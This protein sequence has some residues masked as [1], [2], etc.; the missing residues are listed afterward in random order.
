MKNNF[1]SNMWILDIGAGCHYYRSLEGLTEFKEIDE[2]IK[3]V[4][5]DSRKLT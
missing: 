1:K 5:C 2:S 4:N 3:I